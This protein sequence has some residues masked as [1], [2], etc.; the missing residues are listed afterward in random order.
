MIIY[1]SIYI[2]ISTLYYYCYCINHSVCVLNVYCDNVVIK[3]SDTKDKSEASVHT[4]CTEITIATG[5]SQTRHCS[6]KTNRMW[7]HIPE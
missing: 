3:E 6:T 2:N 4:G 1:Y 5:T 7:Y